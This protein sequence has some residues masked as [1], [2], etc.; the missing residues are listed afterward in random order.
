M[1]ENNLYFIRR[2]CI[3]A[4]PYLGDLK[5]K[6]YHREPRLTDIL[7]AIGKLF[8]QNE[9]EVVSFD[10]KF[11]YFSVF[12]DDKTG[13]PCKWKEDGHKEAYKW[14]LRADSL[15]DQS[16]EAINYLYELLK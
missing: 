5:E 3:E 12:V 13:K 14:N 15:S 2:K 11:L 4:N 7:L 16:E 8:V 6:V 9:R 1:G 10:N